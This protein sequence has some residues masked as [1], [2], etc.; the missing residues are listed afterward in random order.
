MFSDLVFRLRA[1]F[2][3]DT[4]EGEL[5]HELREH[6]ERQVSKYVAA[7]LAPDEARRRARLE[8]GG[9]DQ[10]K[11]ECRDA[12][13]V[14]F[15]ETLLQD[16][17]FAAR[18]LWKTPAVTAV[19][20]LSLALG[21]GANT[22]IFS[23]VDAVVLRT[24]PVQKPDELA[25]IERY[26]PRWGAAS[27]SFTNPLWEQVRDRQDVFSSVFAWGQNRLDLAQG[28]A[29]HL[30]NTVWVSGGFF[31]T[32][33]LR[34]TAGRLI[35]AADDRRGCPAVAVLS[36]GFW[37]EHYGGAPSAIGSTLSLN[38][39]PFEVIGVA[40]S[41]FFGMEVGQKFDV[42]APICSTAIIDGQQSRLDQRS[43]WWLTVAGR[44][45]PGVG[46]SQTAARLQ[47]LSPGVFDAAV[48]LDWSAGGQQNFRK[49]SL[50]ADPAATGISGLRQQFRQPLQVLMGVV[51][52]VLL[53]TCANIASLMLARA[54]ARHKEIAVRQALGASRGRLIRQLMT[55]CLLL[56]SAGALAGILFARWGTA[57]LV[58]YMSTARNTVFLDLSFDGRVLG[59]TAAIAALT[60]FLFGLLPALRS[61][62]V[63]LTSAMKGA[64]ALEIERS[65]RFRARKWIVASQV[66]LSLVLL[67][68]A[69][70]LLR[71][72]AK[73]AT[74]DIGFD[75]NN[76]LLVQ[77][78]LKTAKI[79]PDQQLA[80]YDQ[81]ESRLSALP[82]VVSVGRSVM[83]P[84]S[85][86]AWNNSIHTD[87]SK[88]V[89]GD[90]L[91]AWFNYVS[92]GFFETVRMPL[93]AG[94]VFNAGDT[95]T[96]PAVAI[97][98]QTLA[99][100]FF[101]GLNPVGRTFRIDD[102]GGKL[103]PPIEVVGITKDAKYESL[104]ADIHP[105]A[106]FPAT[107]VPGHSEV[108][109][110]EVRSA[111]PPSV[112]AAP[113]Q[114]AV[115]GVNREIP[116]EFHTLAGLADDSMVQ[117][118]LL[119]LLSGFFGALAL[120]LATIGLYGTLSYLVTQ[121]QAE[122]GIRMALGAQPGSILRLVMQDLMAVL[123]GGVAAGVCISLATTRL[124]QQMLF[125]L[126]GR[127]AV[128]LIGAVA[129][130]CVVALIAGY[131][132]ARRAM[133]VDPMVALRYE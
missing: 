65:S 119:A 64:H 71:S 56:S 57:L 116:L 133:R 88:G 61:T 52:L 11:E 85:G 100:R 53:I 78:D 125:G 40:P 26:N 36:Y 114:A 2:R 117:E 106:F 74:L 7:G 37:Q 30:A 31:N 51:G 46:R 63:S 18:L 67:V 24:L 77:A 105:T 92:P 39:H 109:T 103:G 21:I 13:G 80:T 12:R 4:V 48:P 60:A 79:P 38:D 35:A 101:A 10:I 89:T 69:G 93:L 72:F 127:D 59:F 44:M 118:R 129:V 115:A 33:G 15:I 28:G 128:T 19:A 47:A 108:E 43:W 110:F 104:R 87:W 76:V 99:H 112:L 17:R 45:K 121:R 96:S 20:L 83:T 3:R 8:F 130:L 16:V 97:V 81:T 1:L 107:Q 113:I 49:Q 6:F 124:L 14:S 123:G 95:T 94:R 9:L 55:E 54:A 25:L 42:A 62:H 50:V 66:A 91:L 90:D 131:I 84:I 41:G 29:A 132:P 73:L 120:L 75:R 82:G 27:P 122:F 34:P 22:A 23:L 70:L 111:I 32:L 5:D 68:A 58:R 126:G 86:G 102:A 98:N